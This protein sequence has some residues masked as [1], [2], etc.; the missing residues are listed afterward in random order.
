MPVP[1]QHWTV[2]AE[3]IDVF[4]AIRVVD[5]AAGSAHDDGQGCT[6]RH[7]RAHGRIDA[8]RERATRA[9]EERLAAAGGGLHFAGDRTFTPAV[10]QGWVAVGA[11]D[12]AADGAAGLPTLPP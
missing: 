12:A 3:I 2:S 7:A 5:A 10:R 11:R 1:E 4:A 9:F 6:H 8:A